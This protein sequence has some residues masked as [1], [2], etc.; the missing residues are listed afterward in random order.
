MFSIIYIYR[1]KVVSKSHI[2]Q[3]FSE[4]YVEISNINKGA[5]HLKR[6]IILISEIIF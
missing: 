5:N 4:F 2:N 6:E 3:E 1:Y